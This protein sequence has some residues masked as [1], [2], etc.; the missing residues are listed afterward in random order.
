[1]RGVVGEVRERRALITLASIPIQELSLS[2]NRENRM[3][4]LGKV[5]S[6]GVTSP[7]SHSEGSL[8]NAQGP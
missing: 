8:P 5:L 3:R 6:G 2:L 1:M 7:D 4:P